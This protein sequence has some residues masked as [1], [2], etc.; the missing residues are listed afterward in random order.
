MV[1]W[2][3]W[4]VKAESLTP[5]LQKWLA[6]SECLCGEQDLLKTCDVVYGLAMT[7]QEDLMDRTMLRGSIGSYIDH[8]IVARRERRSRQ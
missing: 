7:N 4:L 2:T 3:P 1:C 6:D 8:V 5:A